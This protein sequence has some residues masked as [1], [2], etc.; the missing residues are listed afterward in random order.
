M[1]YR[2][3]LAAPAL[4]VVASPAAAQSARDILIGAAFTATDKPAALASIDRALQAADA[5]LA[6]DPGNQEAKLQRALAISY[7]GKLKRNRTD[8]V[9]SRKLFEALAAAAPRDAEAQ[10]AI[11]CWHLGGV[12]ELG[13]LVAG[14]MLGAKKAVGMKALDRAVALG[15]DRAFFPALAAMHRI[16]IDPGDIAETT[17][18]AEAAARGST[19]TQ[20]DRIMQKYA[21]A[22]LV[23]LRKGHGAAAAKTAK[24]LLPFGRVK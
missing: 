5:A 19:P 11:G 16:Q 3:L 10:L 13:G 6:R 23:P 12:I 14:T 2:A 1:N 9:A 18:L 7:R 22:L 21:A 15:G 8:I 4:V 24:L 20:A 17:R